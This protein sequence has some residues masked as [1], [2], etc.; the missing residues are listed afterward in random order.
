MCEI[1]FVPAFF[2][3]SLEYLR[4][5]T[6]KVHLWHLEMQCVITCDQADVKLL[7]VSTK[8]AKTDLLT[9]EQTCSLIYAMFCV[10]TTINSSNLCGRHC[11]TFLARMKLHFPLLSC[12]WMAKFFLCPAEWQSYMSLPLIVINILFLFQYFPFA[13]FFFFFFFPPFYTTCPL[14]CCI[15]TISDI[16]TRLDY[17]YICSCHE[18]NNHAQHVSFIHRCR[19]S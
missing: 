12:G 1:S 17:L 15:L 3:L 9:R 19:V 13:L 2:S 8:N 5:R 4:T 10:G 16:F 7:T 11:K 18:C 6:D 14:P